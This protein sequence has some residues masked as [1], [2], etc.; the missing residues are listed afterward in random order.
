MPSDPRAA[1]R[2]Y[3][4]RLRQ[5]LAVPEALLTEAPGWRLNDSVVEIDA[6]RFVALVE[7]AN[8][9]G[10]DVHQR[11]G[12]LDEALGLWRGDA[13]EEFAGEDW[14]RGEADRLNELRVTQRAQTA[15]TYRRSISTR[16]GHAFSPPLDQREAAQGPR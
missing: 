14:A 10:L 12:R 9:P 7:S 15:A 2:T 3:I 16:M 1:L 13:Y 6:F 4:A 5:V 11:L 8:D